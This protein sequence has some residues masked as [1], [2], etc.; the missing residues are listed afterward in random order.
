[1][2]SRLFSKFGGQLGKIYGGGILTTIGRYAGRMLGS[3]LDHINHEPDEY[4]KFNNIKDSFSISTAAFGQPIPLIFGRA[5]VNGKII[6]ASQIKEIQQYTSEE[7]Y[8]KEPKFLHISQVKNIRHIITCEYYVSL[9]LCLC[10]GEITEIARCWANEQ[11][12]DLKD[13]NFRLYT[14]SE[15]QLP[16]PILGPNAPAFR[17]LSYIVFED[18]PLRDFNNS[19]PD[20]SF[21]VVRHAK[22]VSASH[23]PSLLPREIP[24]QVRDDK[25]LPTEDLI[26]S[27]VIIPGSGEFVYDTIMQYKTIHNEYGAEVSR[28]AINS[29]NYYN[30]ADSVHNLNQLQLTIPNLEWVAVTACWFGDSLDISTCRIE[31]CI[32]FNDPYVSYSEDWQVS[33]YSRSTAKPISRDDRGN[34]HY[35]GSANDASLLRYLQEIKNRNLKIMFYPLLLLD[36]PGKPWRGHLSGV[37]GAMRNFFNKPQGYNEFIIHYAMLVKDYADSFIIG[38]EFIGLT[39]IREESNFPAV[40][41]LIN[42]AGIVKSIMGPKIQISYGA[43][44]SEY[45][46]TDG[47]WYNL[48]PLWACEYIDFIGIDAYFPASRTTDSIISE[49]E[50]SKGWQSGEGYDY[51]IDKDVKIPLS[52]EYAWKNLCFWWENQHRNPDGQITPWQPKMKKICFTEFGFPSIDK[53]PNQPNIFFDPLCADGGLPLYSSGETDF[54]LQHRCI[55]AFIE[56]WQMHEF[57]E[58]MFLWCWDAR[59]YPA[60]PHTGIWRDS[61]L[62]EKG[63]WINN[64]FGTNTLAAII[65]EL[66]EKCGIDTKHVSV[67]SLDISVEGIAF[68]RHMSVLDA[69]NT[70]RIGY[71]FDI[72][73]SW[74]NIIQFI[75][76]SSTNLQNIDNKNLVKFSANSFM[77]Q[78]IITPENIINTVALHFISRHKDYSEGYCLV[79]NENTSCMSNTVIKLP[80]LLSDSE[81]KKLGQLILKNAASEDKII[82]FK[83]LANALQYQPSDF[84]T[85][86]HNKQVWHLRITEIKLLGLVLEFTAIVDDTTNYHI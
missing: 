70:L 21:E 28:Q 26:K 68:D 71:F 11:L 85:L 6:W 14:G 43:D 77:E 76:R 9:A 20:F 63:H 69:M 74:G 48:D 41:E 12:L 59:P 17:G 1:M 3:Y 47:G 52:P 31:P 78:T 24:K 38:S 35:G 22:L 61:R 36:V 81:A 82:K 25:L 39:K 58:N 45:H 29:H 23:E 80:L 32:E 33:Y 5:R 49:E 51:Y 72:E 54:A 86:T 34:P 16:D 40:D 2:F 64:K 15:E 84:V 65:Q 10:E 46:H 8:F 53:A 13:Y 30:I 27:I 4:Y 83:L 56:Y 42:L 18:L 75:K 50:L 62:W 67:E 73:A 55:R 66:S 60:W 37:A 19:I 7:K 44:W 57:I 79:A